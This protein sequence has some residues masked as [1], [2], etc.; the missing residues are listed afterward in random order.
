MATNKDATPTSPHDTGSL[1]TQLSERLNDMQ[2]DL[3]F[4]VEAHIDSILIP[5]IVPDAFQASLNDAVQMP[6]SLDNTSRML[7]RVSAVIEARRSQ[8]EAEKN[9]R[10]AA[11][12]KR[13]ATK[14]E[15][16][17]HRNRIGAI[18]VGTGSLLALPPGLLLTYFGIASKPE[19]FDFRSYWPAYL[20]VWL[21]FVLLAT[22]GGFFYSRSR[23]QITNHNGR[24]EDA[25]D[26]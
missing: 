23:G 3:S 14:N 6:Q 2:L 11:K 18:I 8:L 17:E 13:E 21:P 22:I 1:V 4:G 16:L 5:E 26:A 9:E 7:Q 24:G 15:H 10:E 25:N 20:V 12:N 19:I